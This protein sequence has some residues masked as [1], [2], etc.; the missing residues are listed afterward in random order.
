LPNLVRLG[1]AV[2]IDAGAAATRGGRKSRSLEPALNGP[3]RR[4]KASWMGTVQADADE[5]STPG[6]VVA[7]QAQRF[8]KEFAPR[9]RAGR[10]GADIGGRKAIRA[11][12]SQP[13][14]QVPHGAGRQ[15]QCL[16]DGCRRVA[17]LKTTLN[18]LTQRQW[19][20]V[21]HERSSQ[22]LGTTGTSLAPYPWLDHAAKP[23]VGI[24]RQNLCPN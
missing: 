16:G 13:L 22:N 17:L 19:D 24:S 4:E 6:G 8:I 23:A 2:E 5:A 21:R 3:L 18:D 15:A 1:G 11:E 7:A 9:Q 20:G 14:Q 10:C 12:L